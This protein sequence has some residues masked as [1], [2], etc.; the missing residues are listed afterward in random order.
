[1]RY[2]PAFFRFEDSPKEATGLAL[3]YFGR[4]AVLTT[5]VFMGPALLR[6]ATEA[7]GCSSALSCNAR[8]LFMKPSSLLTNIATVAGLSS[9]LCMPLFGAIVDHTPHRRQVG[10]YTAALL[11]VATLVPVVISVHTWAFVAFFQ[12][13]VTCLYSVHAVTTYAYNA[14]LASDPA[15]QA[16]YNARFAIVQNVAF[17][18]FIVT[19]LTISSLL[20]TTVVWTAR[21]SQLLAT[22]MVVPFFTVAWWDMFGDRPASV[23]LPTGQ[24]VWTAGFIKLG[25]TY[26]CIQRELPAV[27]MLVFAVGLSEPAATGI[28]PIA[29]TFF[30]DFLEMTPVEIGI[31]YLLI[32]LSGIVGAKLGEWVST[33]WNPVVSNILAIVLTMTSTTVAVVVLSTPQRKGWSYLFSALWG[34]LL[35][36]LMTNDITLFVTMTPAHSITEYMG[37]YMF[38]ASALSWLPPLTFTILDNYGVSMGLGLASTNIFLLLAL[39][40]YMG[41]GDYQEAVAQ[42]TRCVLKSTNADDD[43]R[44]ALP[45]D[46]DRVPTES[47]RLNSNNVGSVA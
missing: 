10:I 38:S 17:G 44:A 7:M 34:A 13:A 35:T 45:L 41:L 1:M 28:L 43:H 11:V 20:H 39:L 27:R 29:V 31:N 14:E 2:I 3:D 33:R 26:R 12:V 6:L 25:K 15:K 40:S 24:S 18:I 32:L 47:S 30:T 22:L 8:I 19:V 9:G 23:E 4:G 36:W 42:A 21:I 16:R 46:Y 5:A 37:L